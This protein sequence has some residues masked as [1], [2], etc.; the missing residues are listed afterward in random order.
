MPI[1]S[2]T[3]GAYGAGLSANIRA[4]YGFL[5]H[6]YD[7]N[8]GDEIFFF[9]FSRGA[10]TARST[11]G[12]VNK[13]GLLTKRGMDY[14]PDVY[15]EFHDDPTSKPDFEFS[16]E[17]L[18]KI[19]NDVVE[20][21]KDAVKIVG[22]WDTVEFHGEGLGEEKIEF[23]NAKLS[24]RVAYA[25][26]ALSLDERRWPSGY[27]VNKDGTGLQCMKQLWFSGAHSD[28][29]GGKYDPGCSGIALGWMLAHCNKDKKLALID[30]DPYEPTNPNEY[31]LLPDRLKPNPNVHWTCLANKPDPDPLDT[32]WDKAWDKLQSIPSVDRKAFSPGEY[33]GK[34]PSFHQRSESQGLAVWDAHRKSSWRKLGVE[35]L[36]RR[37][38]WEG[39]DAGGNGSGRGPD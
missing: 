4:A 21:A 30:E 9:G 29:G 1:F 36:L 20:Q 2:D 34:N 33:D 10:Y 22:V 24:P 8:P 35:A 25:Y 13:L 39:S 5:A 27:E 12:L 19:G 18:K 3:A 7:P 26:H 37:E 17:L 23:H 32:W 38:G 31:Y 14:F 6:N 11:A 28:V 15:D 16:A